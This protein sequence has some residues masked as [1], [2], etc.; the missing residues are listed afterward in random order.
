MGAFEARNGR[1]S[2]IAD[3]FYANISQS[4]PTP[5]GVLFSQVEIE[6]EAKLLS[7]Y[8]GYRVFEG[9]QIAVDLM[10]GFR[11]N[12][13]DLDVSL[14]PDLLQGQRFG[15]SENLGRSAGRRA[16]AL[17]HHRPVVRDGLRRRR[18]LPGRLRFD[19]ADI[20]EPRLPD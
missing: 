14:A 5:L 8:A 15:M 20:R 7:G 18:R 6:T 3:L 4:R 16:R 10:A 9:G 1:W 11:V 13:V 19:L 2:L 12:S 17:R